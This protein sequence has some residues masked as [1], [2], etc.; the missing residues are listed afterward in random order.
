MAVMA[1]ECLMNTLNVTFKTR[2]VIFPHSDSCKK[3]HLAD[4]G[5][6][7][8]C[9]GVCAYVCA[10]P[11]CIEAEQTSPHAT[12]CIAQTALRLPGAKLTRLQ[13]GTQREGAD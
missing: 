7:H 8:V 2:Q 5:C 1:D 3:N 10:V 13:Q 6:F 11:S 12:Q 9:A 4:R